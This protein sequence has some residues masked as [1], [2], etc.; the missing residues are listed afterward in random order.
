MIIGICGLANSGKDSIADYLME[1]RPEF[2]KIKMAHHLKDVVSLLFGMDRKMLEGETPEDREKREVVDEYWNDKVYDDLK[3][4]TPRKALQ[5]FGTNLLR[6]QMC[7]D[8]W[9]AC[10]EK[11][12][13]DKNLDNIVISDVRFPNEIDM[14]RKLGGVIIRVERGE[15]PEYWKKAE[16]LGTYA[17]LYNRKLD[18]FDAELK[19]VHSSEWQWIGYDNPDVIILNDGTLEDLKNKVNIQIISKYF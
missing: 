19:G 1:Y 6:N 13:K 3:P 10:L 5:Y 17:R 16:E 7:E 4:F 9:V 15:R 2:T 18:D 8:M 12:I 11:N 14:I